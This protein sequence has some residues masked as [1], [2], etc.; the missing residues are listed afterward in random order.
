MSRAVRDW[1]CTEPKCRTIVSDVPV[2]VQSQDCPECGAKMEK[3]WSA[4][5]Q[6]FR[7]DGWTPR[8]HQ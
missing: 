3:V 8:F 2:D 7:G 4:P 6:I 5:T 1:R